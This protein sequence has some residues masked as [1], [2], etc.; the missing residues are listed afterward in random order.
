M[1]IKFLNDIDLV[2][3][4]LQNFKVDNVTS[5]PSGLAGEGQMIY[6]TDTNQLKYHSGGNTWVTLGDAAAAGTVTSVSVVPGGLVLTGSATV[7]PTLGMDYL[8]ASGVNNF[9]MEATSGATPVSTDYILFND[10][11]AGAF[12]G[13]VSRA[14]ISDFPGFGA[15]GTV[16]N[17]STVD[18]G[19]GL[20]LTTVSPTAT[21]TITL[22][23]TLNA[24]H[25]GTGQTAYTVGDI[26]YASSTTAL[27][28]LAIGSTGQ[29]LKVAAGIPSWAADTNTGLTSVG[30]TETGDAL[31][32][33]NSPLTANGSI[34]IA[35]AGSSSQVILGD[36]NLATISSIVGVT[37]IGITVGTGLDVSN[38]PIT[39]T[40]DIDITLDLD[41]LTTVTTIDPAADFLVGV[42]TGTPA[43]NVKTL[44]SNVHLDQWGDAEADVDFGGN[45]LL[46]VATGTAASDGVNLAQVQ[47]IAAG[48]GIFQG[49]YN[50]N[51]NT[52]ALTGASNVA[53]V[54]GDFYVV[55][56]GGSFFT[57]TVEVGDLIFANGTIAASSSPALSAYTVV[58]A[59]Q[60]IAG[61]GTT[62]G[63]TQKGV[64]GFDSANFS[65][66]GNGW[67][68]I[69]NVALGTETSGNYTASVA[70]STAIG[71]LG[72]DISG[73]IGEGQA[74]V[75]GVDI[76]SQTP[77]TTVANADE[78][79]IYDTSTLTNKKVSVS[80]LS[81]GIA[82]ANTA[83]FT[84]SASAGVTH[85]FGT[86]DVIVQLYDIVTYETVYAVVDRVTA[87]AVD[88]TF[89]ATP[90]NS[91]RVLVSKVI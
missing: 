86:R 22:A 90:T 63:N 84:I 82:G 31:T 69:T 34:N 39:S 27:S 64:A 91:I 6:R 50:A 11:S 48:V 67:V 2:N 26:L 23:G 12:D 24:V 33:T 62:D 59:D 40:G 37:S 21:P 5:D 13:T 51:T 85:N 83:A 78:L 25:G 70:A 45:K 4:E 38:S 32:I 41:E 9:I 79:L 80:D 53:L 1:A 61:S 42:R 87:N 35:G 81:A 66:S 18:T 52:P 8:G 55:T 14:L 44:Y 36:L 3:N 49:G 20:T 76:N 15:D 16:T 19:M 7:T 89:S 58:L 72:I 17:V 54:Q 74:A 60:N 46:D 56:T 65:V 47:A 30:I 43:V 28:K 88:I 75:V 29:V 77:L 73:A 57:E 71:L 68:Q 10:V